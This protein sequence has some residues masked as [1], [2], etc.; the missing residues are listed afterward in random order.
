MYENVELV[1]DICPF[2]Y[3]LI[4]SVEVPVDG[5]AISDPS[6]VQSAVEVETKL[7][8]EYS[9]FTALPHDTIG[10]NVEMVEE[11]VGVRIETDKF[12]GRDDLV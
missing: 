7:S 12:G 2:P 6:S 8:Y 1:V 9:H 10:S 11:A 3:P 5:S 4:E